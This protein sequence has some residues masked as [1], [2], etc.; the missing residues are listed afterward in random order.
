MRAPTASPPLALI[1]AACLSLLVAS[2]GRELPTAVGER[3]LARPAGD[4]APGGQISEG[5]IALTLSPGVAPADIA[6]TYGASVA[7]WDADERVASIT[8]G[9]GDDAGGLLA[10]LASDPRI[11]TSESNIQFEPSEARQKSF[12]FDDGHNTAESV[13]AQ[14]A[15]TNVH[16]V[17]ALAVSRGDGVRIA[18]LDTGIDPGH[19]LFAGRIVAAYDFVDGQPGATDLQ[20]GLDSNGDGVVDGA[21]GH[22][23]HV[24]GI[25][26]TIAPGARLLIGRV[27]NSDGQ[28]DVVS[29]AAGIRWA[30]QNGANVINLSLGSLSSS[31]AVESALEEAEE[32]HVTVFASAG[33]WGASTPQE[34]PASSEE[35]IAVAATDAYA[36]AAPW[37]SYAPYV[38]ISAPGVAIRSAYPGGQYR[39]WTGTSMSTPFASAAA[40]LLLTMHPYWHREDLLNRLTAHATP[41]DNL[42]GDRVGM[43]GAGMIDIGDALAPDAPSGGDDPLLPGGF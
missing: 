34:Y 8:P 35:A 29:V 42:T 32:H 38:A 13:P 25:V 18:I 3:E 37:S 22:G 41:I 26:A 36:A 19:V 12:A 2:C 17:Q 30:V 21:W 33:N 43:F 39:Q 14:P 5:Q 6:A 15:F 20:Q 9:P 4:G 27:L 16:A 31:C 11:S 23:T 1:L 7:S 28:G 40:A 10:Q 24:A